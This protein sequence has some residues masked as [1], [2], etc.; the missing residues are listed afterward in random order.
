MRVNETMNMKRG[1][2]LNRYTELKA[3]KP[4]GWKPKEPVTP[5]VT[6]PTAPTVVPYSEWKGSKRIKGLAAKSDDPVAECKERIQAL[7][8]ECAILIYGTCVLNPYLSRLPGRFAKCG[9]FRKDGELIVQAEHLVTRANGISFADL[10]NI[11]LLCQDHHLKFKEQHGRLYWQLIEEVVGPERAAWLDR[12]QDEYE[13]HKTH[14]R[15]LYDW[16]KEEMVL[17]QELKRLQLAY[18]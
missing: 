8:R 15:T 2:R 3:K 11:I 18:A 12:V 1:G 14:H 4:W 16:L 7:L 5:P 13:A 17:K 6:D 9:P 10:R